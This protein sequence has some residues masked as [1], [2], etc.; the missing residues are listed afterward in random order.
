MGGVCV[1]WGAD[2][3]PIH[4]PHRSQAETDEHGAE[5]QDKV[6]RRDASTK[7]ESRGF[8]GRVAGVVIFLVHC[9]SN[10]GSDVPRRWV[11]QSLARN[12]WGS[13]LTNSAT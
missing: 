6:G 4:G 7:V 12:Q 10:V 11:E 1:L 9:R 5:P 3:R 8:H 13:D 2:R